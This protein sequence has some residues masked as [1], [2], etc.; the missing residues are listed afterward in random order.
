MK[1]ACLFL[2]ALASCDSPLDAIMRCRSVCAPLAV[3]SVDYAPN[4]LGSGRCYCADRR[5][6]GGRP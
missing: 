3:Q 5:A 6:D 4:G 1:L 2:L